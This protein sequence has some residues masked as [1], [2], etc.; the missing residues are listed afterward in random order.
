MCVCVCVRDITKPVSLGM[1]EEMPPLC[2]GGRAG[3]VCLMQRLALSDPPSLGLTVSLLDLLHERNNGQTHWISQ[4]G[5]C[6]PLT[7]CTVLL[8]LP[9]GSQATEGLTRPTWRGEKRVNPQ[10]G[11]VWVSPVTRDVLS[12]HFTCTLWAD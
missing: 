4:P 3:C 5:P 6:A 8:S 11:S 10:A 2:D 1:W 9:V 12:G 7:S